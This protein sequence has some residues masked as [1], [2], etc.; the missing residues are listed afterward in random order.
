MECSCKL[1]LPRSRSLFQRL[2]WVSVFR[3]LIDGSRRHACIE[4]CRAAGLASWK[5]VFC[6]LLA[7]PSHLCSCC[8]LRVDARKPSGFNLAGK[9]KLAGYASCCIIYREE[10]IVYLLA[11]FNGRV[12]R[13]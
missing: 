7:Q 10:M 6:E 13:R 2:P 5:Y 4:R 11:S 9:W 12:C 8:S 3:R 1:L